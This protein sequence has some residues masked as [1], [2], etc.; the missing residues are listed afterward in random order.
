MSERGDFWRA[1][2]GIGTL[3]AAGAAVFALFLRDQPLATPPNVETEQAATSSQEE[4]P[5]TTE[6][7]ERFDAAADHLSSVEVTGLRSGDTAFISIVFVGAESG[8]RGCRGDECRHLA[9]AFAAIE[10]NEGLTGLSGITVTRRASA[11]GVARYDVPS[12][13]RIGETTFVLRD[14]DLRVI[15]TINDRAARRF[16]YRITRPGGL[17]E[18]SFSAESILMG[19]P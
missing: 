4:L 18:V 3:V 14:S 13:V 6:S 7:V 12:Q 9:S 10:R 15:A 8:S 11:M 2:T 19:A 17:T 1:A 5:E 16:R